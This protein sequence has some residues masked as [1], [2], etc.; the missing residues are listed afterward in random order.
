MITVQ[1]LRKSYGKVEA[2]KNVSFSLKR[3]EIVALLG[4]NG[5]GKS[6]SINI[7]TGLLKA[8]AGTVAIDDIN[9]FNDP[10]AARQKIGVFPDKAGL[11]P[12]LT[13]REHLKFFGGV[14]GLGGRMLDAVV[15]QTIN[16]LEI[17]DLA[18]RLVKGF[19]QGQ[20]VKTALARATVHQPEFLVLDEP[21]RGLDVYAVRQLRDLLLKLKEKGVGI[22]FSSHVMQEI[23]ILADRVVIIADGV[24][25]AEGTCEAIKAEA[26]TDSLEDAFLTLAERSAD[27]V[28]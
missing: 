25:R 1:G 27:H 26:G 12:N 13:V 2:L 17:E 21:S 5:S 6:T 22:L 7:L 19:S 23:E 24:V 28:S 15:D 4:G 8:D 3:G 18:D 16:S 20:T 11:F 14:N 9:P 10:V